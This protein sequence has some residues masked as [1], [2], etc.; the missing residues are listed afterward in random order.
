MLPKQGLRTGRG[1][2]LRQHQTYENSPI[3]RIN[4]PEQNVI[5]PPRIKYRSSSLRLP[6][7]ISQNLVSLVSR[8]E[9]LDALSLPIHLPPEPP[10]PLVSSRGLRLR[11]TTGI[12]ASNQRELSR[13][14]SLKENENFEEHGNH[15]CVNTS[16]RDDIINSSSSAKLA[17]PKQTNRRRL[18][19]AQPLL[20]H[21]NKTVSGWISDFSQQERSHEAS[22]FGGP[23]STNKTGRKSIR[24]MIKLYDGSME[25]IFIDLKSTN[26][27][28]TFIYS[29]IKR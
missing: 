27:A 17:S 14:S 9:A 16:E 20:K 22:T 11:R 28:Y 23:V 10:V 12:G 8:F 19:R 21:S 24:D 29:S 18:Q 3:H 1:H 25:N 4:L 6:R 7:G 2:S 13:I 5:S 15:H 26:F